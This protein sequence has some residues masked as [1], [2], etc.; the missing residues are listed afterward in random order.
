MTYTSDHIKDLL[1]AVYHDIEDGNVHTSDLESFIGHYSQFAT[2]THDTHVFVTLQM[3][4][5]RGGSYKSEGVIPADF[6]AWLDA[7]NPTVHLG[8]VNGKHSD[9]SCTW[10]ELCEASTEDHYVVQ[11]HMKAGMPSCLRG[12]Y[13]D[14]NAEN[15]KKGDLLDEWIS[16]KQQE[17]KL[18]DTDEDAFYREI[19]DNF[20]DMPLELFETIL[21]NHLTV[22]NKLK[23]TA[24]QKSLKRARTEA[25]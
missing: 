10:E 7:K 17:G 12:L 23:E 9:V 6:A 19:R 20:F 24:T 14:R 3:D 18:E 11:E 1:T 2:K 25:K 5:D 21:E 22:F 16:K 13:D 8:E 15:E 4:F